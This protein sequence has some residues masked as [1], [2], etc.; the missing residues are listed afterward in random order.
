MVEQLDALIVHGDPRVQHARTRVHGVSLIE[1]RMDALDVQLLCLPPDACREQGYA[2][3][4]HLAARR[5][6][7]AF[8]VDAATRTLRPLTD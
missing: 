2:D 7:Q 3:P 5:I 6:R 1:A 4:A 8:V